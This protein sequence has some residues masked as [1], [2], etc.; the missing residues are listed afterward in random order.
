MKYFFVPPTLD[1]KKN[2]VNRLIK[3]IWPKG[4]LVCDAGLIFK[5][6]H[7]CLELPTIIHLSDNHVYSL[8]VS[9]LINNLCKHF[10]PR[11]GRTICRA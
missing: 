10:G 3:K 7:S 4:V 8:L 5:A 11:S 2:P 1:L 6:T 9:L